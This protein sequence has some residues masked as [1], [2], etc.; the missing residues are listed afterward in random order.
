M[1]ATWWRTFI[2]WLFHFDSLHLA[3][4]IDNQIEFLSFSKKKKRVSGAQRDK[5]I[6]VGL[7]VSMSLDNWQD[8]YW[9]QG[10]CFFQVVCGYL[11][12][13]YISFTKKEEKL[14]RRMCIVSINIRYLCIF[15]IYIDICHLFCFRTLFIYLM[16]YTILVYKSCNLMKCL[17]TLTCPSNW[18]CS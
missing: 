14:G 18:Y 6:I 5:L 1:L 11:L 10:D 8:N 7:G 15:I 16:N 17:L 13:I 4:Y 2:L 3:S 12:V 9:G